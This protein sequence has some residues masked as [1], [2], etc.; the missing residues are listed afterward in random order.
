MYL[1]NKYTRWYYQIISQAKAR[2]IDTNVYTENH[3]IIPKSLGGNNSDSNLVILTAREHFIC[4]WLLTK[5]VS[6]TKHQYQMWNA[7]SCMLY[8][9][10]KDQKRY[11]ITPRIFENIKKEGAKIKSLK[12][13]GNKNPMFGREH[14]EK[15][16]HKMKISQKN[17]IR[18]YSEETRQ[19][20]KN[21]NKKIGPNLK[22]RGENNANYKPGTR[23]KMK[24]TFLAKYGFDSPTKVP[25]KCEH[26]GK[27]GIGIGNYNR[28]HADNC[29]LKNQ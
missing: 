4:H 23:E 7:F 5:M 10:T 14:S 15:T 12:F 16:K 17:R 21:G 2:R 8:R 27:T 1:Q 6:N 11:K 13:L 26:C 20:F 9:I 18:V 24:E 25:Y 19:K 3:H 28:W 29:K 22:L